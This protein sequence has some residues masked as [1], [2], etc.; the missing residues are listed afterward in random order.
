[1]KNFNIGDLVRYKQGSLDN[2]GIVVGMG[3][4]GDY[5]IR[6]INTTDLGAFA[7]FPAP[8]RWRNLELVSGMVK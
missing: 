2:L 1:M 5:L 8:C 4:R 3:R 7:Q 6:F